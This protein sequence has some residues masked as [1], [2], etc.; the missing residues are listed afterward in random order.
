LKKILLTGA[1]GYV[2]GRLLSALEA[3]GET[4]RCLAR[5]P[6][7]LRPRVAPTTEVVQGDITD[8]GAALEGV[9]TAFYLVHTMDARGDWERRDRE[10]AAAFG[11]AARA[12]GVKRIVYLGGLGR[13]PGLSKHLAS[14]QETGRLLAEGVPTIELRASIIIGSGSLSFEMVR[15]LVERLP[16]MITPRWVST[17]AQPIAIEDVLAY[18]LAALD[19]LEEVSGVFEIGGAA[20]VTYGE[21]MREYARQRGLKRWLIPVPVLT[22]RLSS[23]WLRL[24]TPL[25]AT[26]GRA[27]IEGV[28]NETHVVDDRAP[29]V[30]GVRPLGLT[31]AIARALRNEDRA[32]AETRWCDAFGNRPSAAERP[33]GTRIVDSRVTEVTCDPTRA[34]EPIRRLGGANG[35]YYGGL[36]WRIRGVLDLLVGGPGHRRGRRDA[37][38]LRVGDAL[39][40]WRVEAFEPPHRLRLSAEMRL[41]GRAWIQFEVEPSATGALIRQTAIFDPL[42]LAGLCYWYA[43]YPLHQSIF[44]GMLRG[45]AAAAQTPLRTVPYV[46]LER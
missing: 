23:L 25:H 3:R 38:E 15:A 34:F 45:I 33:Y 40:F 27:L 8:A 22:P 4:V 18:L 39:D 31:D 26:V 42:G 13:G 28:R 32:Y 37:R 24:V 43:L 36:L 16:V 7:V 19:A 10:A 46:D 41:P 1:T 30:F 20:A 2:G 11:A 17:R 12:A 35:W 21:I 29:K 9:H 5:R 6:E 14:R 44:S